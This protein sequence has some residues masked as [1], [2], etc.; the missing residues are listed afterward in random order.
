MI[1]AIVVVTCYSMVQCP[2]CWWLVC[3]GCIGINNNQYDS[4]VVYLSPDL[5]VTGDDAK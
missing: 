1:S 5:V 3:V 4:D 2:S